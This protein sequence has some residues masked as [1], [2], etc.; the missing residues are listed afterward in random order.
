MTV[1]LVV[2]STVIGIMALM[3]AAYSMLAQFKNGRQID[4]NL[5][6]IQKLKEEI[7]ILREEIKF[8]MSRE[9]SAPKK[10]PAKPDNQ[11]EINESLWHAFV[12]DYNSLAM[13]MEIPKAA[14]A[15]NAFCAAHG[16]KMLVCTDHA[17]EIGGS[18]AP[19][20]TAVHDADSSTYWA[21]NLKENLYAIVPNPLVPYS[22]KMHTEGGMKE[23]FASNYEGGSY[24]NIQV[25][26][27][28][29]FKNKNGVWKIENPGVIRVS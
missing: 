26:L 27:P 7:S 3:V 17:A 29:I 28:A 11:D 6:E 18:I 20:F 5:A 14:E 21:F 9:Y 2:L 8:R 1:I 13:S 15:C 16:I 25:K 19:K 10:S 22:E 24:K 23:T 4:E 12:A